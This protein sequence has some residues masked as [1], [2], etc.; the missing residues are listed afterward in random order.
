L[1]LAVVG[2]STTASTNVMIL[3]KGTICYGSIKGHYDFFYPNLENKFELTMAIEVERL[4]WI[5]Y[6]D[7]KPMRVISPDNYLPVK[8]LWI[9]KEPV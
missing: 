3:K 4:P 5:S 8:V 7:Y 1:N 9:S 2:S 6:D